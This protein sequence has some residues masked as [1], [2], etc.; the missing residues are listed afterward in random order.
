MIA[1][2]PLAHQVLLCCSACTKTQFTAKL[3]H[4]RWYCTDMPV[5]CSPL[6][7]TWYDRPAGAHHF[8]LLPTIVTIRGEPEVKPS[9]LDAS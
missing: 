6:L 8:Q 1:K 3:C 2:H 9:E 4:I 7:A 5:M